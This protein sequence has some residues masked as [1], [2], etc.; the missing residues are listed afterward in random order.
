MNGTMDGKHARQMR[1]DP[2]EAKDKE[3]VRK[4]LKD[5]GG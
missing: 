4:N 3:K 5:A 1:A 2:K